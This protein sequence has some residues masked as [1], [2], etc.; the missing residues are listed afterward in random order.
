M[1]RTIMNG[2]TSTKIFIFFHKKDYFDTINNCTGSG[3]PKY[4]I[5][6]NNDGYH[7][8][9]TLIIRDSTSEDF[10]YYGCS[11]T[12]STG[13]DELSIHLDMQGK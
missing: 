11:V 9:S 2:M 12:N 6:S 4:E 1:G 5:T 3:N 7:F 13:G 8:Q 10:G